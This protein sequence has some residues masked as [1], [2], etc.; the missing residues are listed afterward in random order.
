[1]SIVFGRHTNIFSLAMPEPVEDVCHVLA[2]V[3]GGPTNPLFPRLTR[4]RGNF[5]PV[6]IHPVG[7]KEFSVLMQ[8]PSTQV[9]NPNRGPLV[10]FHI[11]Q[12]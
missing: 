1:M 5:A 7:R 11:R 12:V 8:H 3:E 10:S 4:A 6:L 2:D 9:R